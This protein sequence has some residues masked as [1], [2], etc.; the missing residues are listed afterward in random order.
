MIHEIKAK[1]LLTHVPQPDPWFGLRYNM[2][3]YRG[4][5]HQC[6]YCDSRSECYR[7]ENFADI[8]IKVNALE[9]L[10][11]E[12]SRKRVIGTIGTG[13]MNDPYMP[14]EAKINLTGRALEL[15]AQNH[16]PVHVIT[17]SALVTR[18]LEILERINRTF[19]VVSFSI[20]SA[21]DDLASVVEPG[22]SRPSERFRAMKE[23]SSAGIPTGV[24]MMPVLPFIEDDHH[25]VAQIVSLAKENGAS[26]IL[27]SFG[28][29]L[30]DRQRAYYYS[31]LDVHFPGIRK[32]YETKFK[33]N[34]FAPIS[35][36]ATFTTYFQELCTKHRLSTRIPR[37][38]TGSTSQLSLF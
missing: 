15:I 12:L 27:P 4:C 19:A 14:L 31:K 18:D 28:V 23:I 30:R 17:K 38:Q 3:L 25:N 37:F 11:K 32:Q 13:S 2:N 34:Y 5:Q 35:N 29:T 22:A 36:I 9:L 24:L 16:F 26:Y 33:E 8:L 20:T 1:V 10:E 21:N 7:I 6:I